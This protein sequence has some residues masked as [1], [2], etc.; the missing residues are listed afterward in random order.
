MLSFISA[1]EAAK[2]WNISQRRVSVLCNE[3]RIDGAM[4][5]G[6]MWIIPSTAQKPVDKRTIKNE[7]LKKTAIKPFVKWA[8]GKSQVTDEIEKYIF[9]DS[10]KVITK[11]AEPMVGGGALAFELLSKYNFE[12][13]YISDSNAELINAYNVIK[14]DVKPLISKLTEMQLSFLPMDENGRKFYYYSVRDKFNDVKLSGGTA[15]E[16]AAQFIFLNKTC[17][18]GLYRVNKKGQFNVPMGL[19]KN[20]TICDETN[21]VNLSSALQNVEIV[22]GDY[23]FSENFIDENT[24]VY[25]DPPYRPISQTSGFTSYNIDAFDDN[26]QR[27]LAEYVDRI[28]GKGAKFVL[29]NSDPKNTNQEDNFFD[30]LYSRY[31]IERIYAA[32]SVNSKGGSRGKISELLIHN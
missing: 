3:R 7:E 30:D 1:K 27:R 4:M 14:S 21:L 18:N 9:S 19:Y 15:V 25:I 22:C 13:Y 32:R 5:V 29:S 12:S 23:T 20:P 17:F 28:N 11:Y 8:G 24:F 2:K 26:E 10:G 6:N 16:K 31:K